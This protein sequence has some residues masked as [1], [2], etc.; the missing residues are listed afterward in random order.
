MQWEIFDKLVQKLEDH[1]KCVLIGNEIDYRRLIAQRSIEQAH[2][3][4]P[5]DS[6]SKQMFEDMWSEIT[7]KY[8]GNVTSETVQVMFGRTLEVPQSCNGVARFTFEY[9]CGRP[10]GAADYIAIANNYHT[11]FITDIP[12][13]SMRIRDKARRF[14]TL[15]DELYNRHCCLYCSAEA[16]IDDLFQGT[17]EGTLFDMESFQ[18]ETEIEGGRLRRD[19]LAEGGI[20]SGGSPTGIIS[21]LSGQE[22]LFAFRRAVSRL[23]E[24]QSRVYLDAA[25]YLHPYFQSSHGNLQQ[26]SSAN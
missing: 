23:I 25:R 1:C 20:S 8:G 15:I 10:I 24:M 17:E 2:Y 14:I 16:S 9:L 6:K 12:V 7:K 13:M 26:I 22:E 19:V 5:L 4:W 18:F 3:Y 11:V 21:M